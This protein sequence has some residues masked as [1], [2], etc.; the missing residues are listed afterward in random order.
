MD[1]NNAAP[2][3]PPPRT[4]CPAT[5]YTKPPATASRA[6]KGASERARPGRARKGVSERSVAGRDVAERYWAE[7][8]R[9]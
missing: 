3:Q 9:A 1:K 8:V 4:R 7:R 5:R 2:P 6:R